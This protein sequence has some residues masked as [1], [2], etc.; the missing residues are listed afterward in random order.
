MIYSEHFALSYYINEHVNALMWN[1]LHSN[2]L[3]L[4]EYLLKNEY[5]KWYKYTIRVGSIWGAN[6]NKHVIRENIILFSNYCSFHVK[7]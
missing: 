5:L 7:E 2:N 6:I 1:P 3:T 4:F